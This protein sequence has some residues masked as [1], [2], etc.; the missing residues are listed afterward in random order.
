MK[1]GPKPLPYIAR[2][3]DRVILNL[4]PA[5]MESLSALA[6]DLSLKPNELARYAL[7]I[8]L[9]QMFDEAEAENFITELLIKSRL[10]T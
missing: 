6:F 10:N 2:R 1:P 5:E 7:L 3:V 8:G 4:Y 9:R